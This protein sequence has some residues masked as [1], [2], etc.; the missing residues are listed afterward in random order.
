MQTHNAQTQY[1]QTQ[2]NKTIQ[3]HNTKTRN[4]YR[5]FEHCINTQY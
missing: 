4:E 1:K 2:H 3:K 5:V